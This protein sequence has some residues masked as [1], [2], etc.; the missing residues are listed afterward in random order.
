MANGVDRVCHAFKI[1]NARYV[2]DCTLN[3]CGSPIY[4]R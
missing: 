2:C 3:A 1:R 4:S